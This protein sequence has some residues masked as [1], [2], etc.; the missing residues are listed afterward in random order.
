M[1]VQ[2]KRIY[3]TQRHPS[4]TPDRFVSRWRQ[5]GQLAMHFMAKQ[6]WEN[7]IRY[8]HCDA[9]HDSGIPGIDDQWDGMGI[10]LFRDANARKRHIAFME[11]RAALEADEDATFFARVNRHGFVA[12]EQVLHPGPGGRI[13]LVR[14][15]KR[16]EGISIAD[17]EQ[18][19][20]IRHVPETQACF[21]PALLRQVANWPL[22]PE[23]ATGWGLD[24]D[25]VEELWFE[26]VDTLRRSTATGADPLHRPAL[27]DTA[28]QQLAVVT[29][30][31][32]LYP[33]P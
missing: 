29:S 6:D 24:C 32:Q 31:L 5:H 18:C 30:E 8:V 3:F 15:F 16:L 26:S 1:N 23:A 28:T 4:L 10:I 20:Q 7:V 13:K 22:L 14:A 11:A 21:S 12:R 9:V 33:A 19:W 25:V 27:Q 2:P 17:F